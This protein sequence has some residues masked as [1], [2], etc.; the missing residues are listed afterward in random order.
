MKPAEQFSIRGYESS[1]SLSPMLELEGTVFNTYHAREIPLMTPLQ[2]VAINVFRPLKMTVCCVYLLGAQ[3]QLADLQHL[4]EQLPTPILLMGD[5][6]HSPIWGCVTM[7]EP[8][9]D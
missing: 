3:Y 2:A 4:I 6:A 5:N 9:V 1:H 8:A 7:N